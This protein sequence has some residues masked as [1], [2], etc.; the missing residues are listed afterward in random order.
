MNSISEV[1]QNGMT[2]TRIRISIPVPSYLYLREGFIIIRQALAQPL[3]VPSLN[4][5]RDHVQRIRQGWN[6]SY[7]N[8]YGK[9]LNFGNFCVDYTSH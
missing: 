2:S 7:A 5:T 1:V 6:V 8:C 3:Q 4:K 9:V